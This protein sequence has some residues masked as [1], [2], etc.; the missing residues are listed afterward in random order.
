MDF[1]RVPFIERVDIDSRLKGGNLELLRLSRSGSNASSD[2]TPIQVQAKQCVVF[3]N[4]HVYHRMTSLTYPQSSSATE[5]LARRWIL[6]FFLVDPKKKIRSSA[7]IPVNQ[8]FHPDRPGPQCVCCGQIASSYVYDP[9]R[10]NQKRK[11]LRE[12]RTAYSEKRDP[13]LG[14]YYGGQD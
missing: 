1:T 3:A 5:D 9:I 14:E 8:R 4:D 12:S 7:V 11:E 10:A 2:Y 6:N 13:R